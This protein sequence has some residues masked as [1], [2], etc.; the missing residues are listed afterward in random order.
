MP[1]ATVPHVGMRSMAGSVGAMGRAMRAA[2]T[3]AVR[4]T[5]PVLNVDAVAVPMAMMPHPM[6]KAH[7]R[8]HDQACEARNQ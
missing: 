7:H 8:H 2:V 3:H 4:V 1:G 5:W 6:G